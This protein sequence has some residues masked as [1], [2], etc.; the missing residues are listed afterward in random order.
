MD[1]LSNT[2]VMRKITS[3]EIDKAR[4]EGLTKKQL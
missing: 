1:S 3:I 2:K 4:N